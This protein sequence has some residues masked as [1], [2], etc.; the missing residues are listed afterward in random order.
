MLC[1]PGLCVCGLPVVCLSPCR[2]AK[3]QGLG[4]DSDRSLLCYVIW[5]ALWFESY[6]S[7][8]LIKLRKESFILIRWPSLTLLSSSE[9]PIQFSRTRR[10]V[11]SPG[12]ACCSYDITP[13]ILVLPAGPDGI[14]AANSCQAAYMPLLWRRRCL[15]NLAIFAAFAVLVASQVSF[16]H[17]GDGG[18]LGA[19]RETAA[20]SIYTA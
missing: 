9:A 7:T 4:L 1:S 15:C 10:P 17:C 2:V 12:S 8:R 19:W 3:L 11:S 18:N 5:H 13:I 20:V 6:Q 16:A 14:S